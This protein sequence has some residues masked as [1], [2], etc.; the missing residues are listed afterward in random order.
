MHYIHNVILIIYNTLMLF[1]DI[2]APLFL[3]EN[4]TKLYK[5]L[6]LF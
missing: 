5:Y 6:Y 4:E 2:A 1:R 3:S